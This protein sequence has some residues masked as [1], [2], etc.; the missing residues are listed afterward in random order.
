MLV[1]FVTWAR[2]QELLHL[3]YVNKALVLFVCLNVKG[4]VI[5]CVVDGQGV[6][7]EWPRVCMS[8]CRC[9]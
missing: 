4:D 7:H 5:S 6:L 8:R 2:L 1:W 9:P 3:F